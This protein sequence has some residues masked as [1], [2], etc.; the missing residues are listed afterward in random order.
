MS[1]ELDRPLSP[2]VPRYVWGAAPASSRTPLEVAVARGIAVHYSA[3]LADWVHSHDDCA[4]RV[5]S[6]QRFHMQDRGWADIA[7]SWVVCHHGYRFLGRDLGI[8]TAAQGTTAGNDAYHAVCF[9]GA[10]AENRD[11]VTD[12]GRRAIIDAIAE[13]QAW[14][15]RPIEVRPHSDFHPTGCPGDELRAWIA[16][17]HPEPPLQEDD[18]PLNDADK[19]EVREIVRGELLRAVQ[20]IGGRTNTVYNQRNADLDHVLTLNDVVAAA[21]P[22]STSSAEPP[23]PPEGT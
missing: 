19:R 3:M 20:W 18:M 22:P 10:D 6:I 9:L 1:G 23:A 11:D 5:R 4:S 13:V 16:G 12:P 21:L 7:Y 8:R 14:A 2:V 17:G 15:H